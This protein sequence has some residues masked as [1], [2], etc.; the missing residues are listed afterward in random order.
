MCF[1]RWNW[2][3]FRTKENVTRKKLKS[4]DKFRQKSNFLSEIS[5]VIVSYKMQ[6]EV[7]SNEKKLLKKYLIKLL[8]SRMSLE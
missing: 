4:L 5:F 7:F 1:W 3:V 8:K 6:K 2:K